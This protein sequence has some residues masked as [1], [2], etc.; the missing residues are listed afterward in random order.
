MLKKSHGKPFHLYVKKILF[1]F[2]GGRMWESNPPRMLLTPHTGFE[3][4]EA[5]QLPIYSHLY[6]LNHYNIIY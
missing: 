3:D 2:T 5:H 4:Q 1:K 6:F